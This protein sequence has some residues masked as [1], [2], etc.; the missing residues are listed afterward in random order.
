LNPLTFIFER[1]TTAQASKQAT[2][3]ASIIILLYH[4]VSR[5]KKRHPVLPRHG[6]NKA[7]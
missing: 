2:N 3:Y 1:A 7:E 5:Q 4:T 6:N